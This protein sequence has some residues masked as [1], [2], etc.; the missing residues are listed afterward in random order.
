MLKAVEAQAGFALGLTL[1]RAQAEYCA[2]KDLAV[3]LLE[4]KAAVAAELG[5]FD[6]IVS[7]PPNCHAV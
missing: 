5:E 2:R 1:S 7:S 6:A 3:R 4:Y